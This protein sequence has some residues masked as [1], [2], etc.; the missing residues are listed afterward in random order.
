[1]SIPESRQEEVYLISL[2][3]KGRVVAKGRLVTTDSRREILGTKLG[4]E[5]WGVYVKGLENIERGNIGDEE[6]PRQFDQIRTVI[7]AIGYVIAWPS[8]HVKKA[9]SSSRTR[10]KLVSAARGQS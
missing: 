4:T 6:I 7:D 1:M 3:N 9:R 5:F 10:N 8:T 2:I